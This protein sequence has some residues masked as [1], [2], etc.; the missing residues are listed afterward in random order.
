MGKIKGLLGLVVMVVI[1]YALWNLV[2]VYLAKV[3]FQDD[4]TSAAKFAQDHNEQQI[5][6]E[7]MKNAR[8]I[9]IPLQ[10]EDLHV[11]RDTGAVTITAD[12]TVVITPPVGKPWVLNFHLSSVKT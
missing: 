1:V 9:G 4:L 2:P 11:S 12:Y 6:D 3:Q 8:D 7:V 10:P 5:H